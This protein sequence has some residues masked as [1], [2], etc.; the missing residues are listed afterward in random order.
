MAGY[1]GTFT[2]S[3]QIAPSST[4][5]TYPTHSDEFT[6][7]GYR[8]VETIALRD[9]I[10]TKRKKE[11]MLVY[12]Q[13]NEKTYV[14]KS[15]VWEEVKVELKV[16]SADDS[17]VLNKVHT[18]KIDTDSGLS[19]SSGDFGEATIRG[20]KSFNSI[21]AGTDSIEPSDSTEINLVSSDTIKPYINGNEIKYKLN[22]YSYVSSTP[23]TNYLIQHNLNSMLVLVNTYIINNDGTFDSVIAPY[24]IVDEN[25][26]SVSLSSAKNVRV[27]IIPLNMIN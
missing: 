11:G 12:V 5:S 27:N 16:S 8:S 15:D 20:S 10:K 2:V 14:L 25:S 22:T 9:A 24:T 7:G 3:S 19:F 17:F 6:L 23:S 13:D 26:I 4:R 1:P 18:I 21:N